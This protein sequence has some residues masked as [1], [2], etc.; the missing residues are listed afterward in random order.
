MTTYEAFDSGEFNAIFK[1][2]VAK[3]MDEL[4]QHEDDD[5][6]DAAELIRSKV[7]GKASAILDRMDAKHAEQ[8][9]YET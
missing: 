4:C 2:Y 6:R 1:G 5:I 8:Y 7:N 9:Y 3:I